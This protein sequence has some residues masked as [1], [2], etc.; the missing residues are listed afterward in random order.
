[1]SYLF[2]VR[3][4]QAGP[5]LF[6]LAEALQRIRHLVKHPHHSRVEL[7]SVIEQ[8]QGSVLHQISDYFQAGEL[9]RAARGCRNRALVQFDSFRGFRL[10]GAIKRPLF[11]GGA[12]RLA[13]GFHLR[14]FEGEITLVTL[15]QLKTVN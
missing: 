14:C 9:E 5:D 13:F 7:S 12:L 1:M 3:H 10:G 8:V 4:Q 11:S 2:V 15:H 6:E